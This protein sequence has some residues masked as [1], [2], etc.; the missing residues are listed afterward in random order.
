VE[1]HTPTKAIALNT[2]KLYPVGD[3]MLM[4][5]DF[6]HDG[7]LDV[8]GQVGTDMVFFPGRGDGSFHFGSIAGFD[9]PGELPGSYGDFNGDGNLDFVFGNRPPNI[10][11]GAAAVRLGDGHGGFKFGS[12]IYDYEATDDSFAAG[13]FNGDGKLDLITGGPRS[14]WTSFSVLLGNG[15]GRFHHLGNVGQMTLGPQEIVAGDF[16]GD[17]K[18]DVAVFVNPGAGEAG[19]YL[20]L[21]PGNGDGTFQP[22]QTLISAKSTDGTGFSM[23]VS[24]FNG[25]GK[26]DIAYQNGTQIFIL[27]GNGD[28][29]FQPAIPLTADG[30]IGFAYAIGDFNSDGIP[31]LLVS[32][33]DNINNPQYYV[34]LGNGDGT[35]QPPQAINGL[36]AGAFVVGDFNSDGLLDFLVPSGSLGMD[37]HMQK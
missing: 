10:P 9:Y 4:V 13:D 24:D 25:D 31:D 36:T 21:F 3:T 1:V 14:A 37:V 15:T 22:Q 32:H 5:A 30:N 7:I 33:D 28:G 6:N 8:V 20:Y 16:N 12:G 35:F 2:Y 17:G 27:L 23:R 34:F 19:T 18:L 11:N 29:T 26:L